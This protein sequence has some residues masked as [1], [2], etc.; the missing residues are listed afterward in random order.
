[1]SKGKKTCSKRKQNKAVGVRIPSV[2]QEWQF[3]EKVWPCKNQPGKLTDWV[4]EFS[5]VQMFSKTQRTSI[6]CVCVWGRLTLFTQGRVLR[7]PSVHFWMISDFLSASLLAWCSR[8]FLLCVMIPKGKLLG[9][10]TTT[11][12]MAEFCLFFCSFC[13]MKKCNVPWTEWQSAW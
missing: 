5:A 10:K 8:R 2:P 4:W 11:K 1:M 7:I 12:K 13:Q 9:G 3:L 6:M